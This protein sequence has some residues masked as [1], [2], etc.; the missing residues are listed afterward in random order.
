MKTVSKEFGNQI[1]ISLSEIKEKEERRAIKL[2]SATK[3]FLFLSSAIVSFLGVT[4]SF[5][6]DILR[7]VFIN[8]LIGWKGMALGPLLVMFAKFSQLV[9]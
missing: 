4:V 1:A 3:V 9:Q 8:V 2:S 7:K 6:L 5:F